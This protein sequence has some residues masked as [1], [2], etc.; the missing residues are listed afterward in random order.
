MYFIKRTIEKVL[1][2]MNHYISASS[3]GSNI[4]EISRRQTSGIAAAAP[5]FTSKIQELRIYKNLQKST[6]VF[7][8]LTSAIL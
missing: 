4:P 7:Y 6:N 5:N 1:N 8:N 2:N 3:G